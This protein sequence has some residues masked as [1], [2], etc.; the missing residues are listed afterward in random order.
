MMMPSPIALIALAS[1]ALPGCVMT[2]TES[3][4]WDDPYAQP[5]T[6]ATAGSTACARSSSASR[7][8]RPAAPSQAP[9]SAA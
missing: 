7:A 1:I 5:R 2:T 6:S 9:S 4:S 8:T 3:R